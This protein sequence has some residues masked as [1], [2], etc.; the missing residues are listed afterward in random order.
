MLQIDLPRCSNLWTE[1]DKDLFNR[2]PIYM[3]KI[4]AE[5]IQY[6]SRWG[7]LLN[8]IPWEANMGY[9]MRGVSKRPSP[10]IRSQAFP[11]AMSALPK[12]DVL[13]VREVKE[14]TIL[15]RQDFES[16]LMHFLPN[17]VDF[18]TDHVDKTNDDLVEKVTVYGDQ[19]Y[20]TAIFHGSPKV[21]VCGKA[22]PMTVTPYWASPN[23]S[24]A[25]DQGTRQALVAQ[26]N[27]MLNAEELSKIA[28]ALYTDEGVVPF[29]GKV[30]SDGTNGEQLKH[31]YCL[32]TATEVWEHL[33][34]DT[35][36][37]ANRPLGMNII[38]D[39]FFG[40]L[41]GR[42]MTMFERFELRI[43]ADGSIPVPET[44]EEGVNAYN[45][46][47][48]IPNPAY[49]NAQFGVAFAVGGEAYRSVR[50]GPPP[51][52]WAGMNMK[53]FSRLDWNGKVDITK[54]VLIPCLDQNNAV[55]LDTNKRGE[56]IQLIS[57]IALGIAP[58]RRR[59]IL[60]I[61]YKRARVGQ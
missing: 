13:E 34:H 19:F 46:G 35:Y 16:N 10:I 37:K 17:F 44:I 6:Y 25:K 60:P 4:Q 55:V 53:Q 28:T 48:P 15:Y 61:I 3:A 23:I 45:V 51:S 38:T 29:S 22:T 36:I 41:F 39:G 9:T 47:E 1:Q 33:V 56:Y 27:Q 14:D 59:N 32:V 31:K 8:T 7:K 2:L 54:N 30:L 52:E 50:I 20:R 58:I 43:A 26:C 57:S 5:F 42:W 21:W 11:N 24:E 12:K 18:L 49:V 40:S